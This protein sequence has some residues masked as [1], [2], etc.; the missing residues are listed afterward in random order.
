MKRS[1]REKT[2]LKLLAAVVLVA[3]VSEVWERYDS[4]KK[5]VERETQNKNDEILAYIQELEGQDPKKYLE[6]V[7]DIDE[8][9]FTARERVIELPTEAEASLIV[10]QAISESAENSGVTINSINVRKSKEVSED[11]ELKE[12]RTYFGY[13]TDLESLLRFFSSFENKSYYMVIE[14]LSISARQRPKRR[15]NNRRRNKRRTPIPERKPLNGNAI[16][17]SLYM[18]DADGKINQYEINRPPIMTDASEM[19]A[20]EVI[21]PTIQTNPLPDNGLEGL[22]NPMDDE[23]FASTESRNR[24]EEKKVEEAPK[25]NSARIT[26]QDP[27]V[28]PKP[29]PMPTDT[30]KEKPK[31]TAKS[32]DSK[33]Q[34]P[35]DE[36]TE[37]KVNV[38]T[39]EKKP[40]PQ[41]AKTE[42][43]VKKPKIKPR[44]PMESKPVS[45]TSPSRPTKN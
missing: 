34:E 7:A 22:Q 3:L 28:K 8:A 17:K 14:N 9:L 35:K 39:P 24:S 16:I 23:T 43:P 33:A 30:T 5:R 6:E 12:L 19:G 13:D 37:T 15:V 36:K 20:T 1:S 26:R 44:R 25:R 29:K 45:L 21:D 32:D 38:V 41:D 42:Q 2:I 31:D 18:P 27:K 10:R 11:G 4:M 40:T